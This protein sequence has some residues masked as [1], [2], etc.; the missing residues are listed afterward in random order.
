MTVEWFRTPKANKEYTEIELRRIVNGNDCF[1]K[2]HD[3][4]A[5]ECNGHGHIAR[6]AEF[7]HCKSAQIQVKKYLE[8]QKCMTSL[9]PSVDSNH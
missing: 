3:P 5:S 6:C 2:L 1:G 8:S 4:K 7:D 9:L